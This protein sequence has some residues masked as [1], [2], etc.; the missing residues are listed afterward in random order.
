MLGGQET[1][2]VQ[3]GFKSRRPD[4]KRSAPGS[5][6]LGFF[7]FM[8][9]R[10]TSGERLPVVATSGLATRPSWRRVPFILGGDAAVSVQGDSCGKARGQQGGD[11]IVRIPVKGRASSGGQESERNW[12]R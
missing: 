7:L 5:I 1:K 10:Q 3:K 9:T 8:V 4:S 12:A 11:A 6:S 2:W